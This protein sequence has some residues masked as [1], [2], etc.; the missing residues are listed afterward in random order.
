M[1]KGSDIYLFI[2]L[3]LLFKFEKDENFSSFRRGKLKLDCAVELENNAASSQQLTAKCET[4][5]VTDF[6]VTV[7]FFIIF[8]CLAGGSGRYRR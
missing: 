4:V 6:I 2:I 7:R 5:M 8:H 1:S 3:Y